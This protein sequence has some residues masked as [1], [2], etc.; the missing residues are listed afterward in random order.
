MFKTVKPFNHI[1]ASSLFRLACMVEFADEKKIE[2]STKKILKIFSEFKEYAGKLKKEKRKRTYHVRGKR[3]SIDKQI[4]SPFTKI[5]SQLIYA[6]AIEVESSLESHFQIRSGETYVVL[7]K[8][9]MQ[10]YGATSKIV[11]TEI[12]G[13]T[14]M[15][16]SE[17][18]EEVNNHE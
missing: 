7:S 6:M 12:G 4:K 14:A 1:P 8:V 2:K 17:R 18:K 13:K 5:G 10:L 11:S 15:N 9:A 3:K 16:R